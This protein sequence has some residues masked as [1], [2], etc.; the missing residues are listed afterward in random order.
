MKKQTLLMKILKKRKEFEKDKAAL[1]RGPFRSARAETIL[2]L[3]E[4]E[5]WVG[6]L[7]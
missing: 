6:K 7:E 1:G 2:A 4:V 3:R 5:K